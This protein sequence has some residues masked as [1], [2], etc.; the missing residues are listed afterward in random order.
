MNDP[1]RP[2]TRAE[3]FAVDPTSVHPDRVFNYLQG[4]KDNFEADRKAAEYIYAALPGGIESARAHVRESARFMRRTV[5]HLTEEVGLRQFLNIGP[6][7]PALPGNVHDIV[8][9][10]ASDGRVV[11]VVRDPTVLAQAHRLLRSSPEGATDVLPGD[12]RDPAGLVARA[13]GTLDLDRPVAVLLIGTLNFVPERR[14]PHR[15]VAQL[16]EPLAPGS[17]LAISHIASDVMVDAMAEA[18]RRQREVT[19]TIAALPFVARSRAQVAAF[20]DGLDLIGPGV[21]EIDLWRPHGVDDS[22]DRELMF[23]TYAGLGRK[24]DPAAASSS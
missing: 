18:A 23:P 15:I 17:Y 24:P 13:G 14:E 21:V 4:G 7:A 16:M 5:R 6:V 22:R 3:P 20:F 10:S 9:R 19:R 2:P 11:Y 8:Q 1:V 12:L